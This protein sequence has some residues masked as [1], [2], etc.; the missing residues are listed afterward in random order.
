MMFVTFIMFFMLVLGVIALVAIALGIFLFI[1][2][3][4]RK[5]QGHPHVKRDTVLGAVL[6]AAGLVML[7]IPVG[8][9]AFL[10]VANTSGND[11][12]TG[13]YASYDFE[14]DKLMVDDRIYVPLELEAYI[15]MNDPEVI[16]EIATVKEDFAYIRNIRT[17]RNGPNLDIVTFDGSIYCLKD[18][19]KAAK[20]W[21][22]DIKKF[23]FSWGKFGDSFD[24]EKKTLHENPDYDKYGALMTFLNENAHRNNHKAHRAEEAYEAA[25][26]WEIVLAADSTDRLLTIIY[27]D[28]FL[29]IDGRLTVICDYGSDRFKDI[30]WYD[31]VEVPKKLSDYFVQA[32]K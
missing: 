14:S 5:K 8:F 18:D 24:F 16:E 28:S 7:L 9:A 10:Y 21:Y 3:A 20:I 29:I 31:V 26:E 22:G 4:N 2:A 1:N 25:R 27:Y 12:D 19:L 11:V 32:I 13:I 30:E 15:T 6:T 17:V 23:D